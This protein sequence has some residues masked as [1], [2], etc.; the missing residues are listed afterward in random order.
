MPQRHQRRQASQSCIESEAVAITAPKEN[1][2]SDLTHSETTSVV[3]WLL[4]QPELNLTVSSNATI[5]DNKIALIELLTP[6]KTDAVTYLQGGAAPKRYAHVVLDVR[7]TLEPYYQDMTVGPLPINNM[8]TWKPYDYILTRKTDGK[9]PNLA[10]DTLVVLNE[11]IPPIGASVADITLD[12]WNGTATGLD[13]DTLSIWS[14]AE[15]WQ[16]DGRTYRWDR[17][18]NIQTDEFDVQSLLPL[19]LYFKSDVTGRDPSK[20][21]LEGWFYNDVFYETTE[22]FRTAYWAGLPKAPLNYEG[23]WTR[24]DQQGPVM[25]YDKMAP[26]VSVAPSGSRFAVDQQRKY[27]EWMDFSFYIGFRRDTGVALYDIRYKGELILYELGLQEAM[28]HYAGSDPVQSSTAYL[29]SEFGF[30]VYAFELV[31]GYDCPE[32]STYLNTSFYKSESTH[33]HLKSICLFEFTADYPVQRHSSSDY[34]SATKNTYFSLRSV[35]TIGNYDYMFTYSFFLD[36]SIS[37]EVRASGYVLTTSVGAPEFG[38]AIH[39]GLSGSIHDH[40][41]NFK[42]DFD[43]LGTSNTMQLIQNVPVT[44]VFPW[45][46]G[47][48]RNTMQLQRSFVESEN[49]SRFNW[50]GATQVLVV[51]TDKPNQWG[52][53]RGYRVAPNSGTARLTVLNSSTIANAAHWSEYDV[54]VT[55]RKDT[56]PLSAHPYNSQAVHDPPINFERFFDDKESLMQQ[57]LVLWLNLGMHHVPH[58]GDLPNTVFTT[59][60]SGITFMPSNYFDIDQTRRTVNMVRIDYSNDNATAVKTFGQSEATCNL[61]AKAANLWDYRG[62]VVVK[63]FPF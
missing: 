50:D 40:V 44:R 55:R 26:P 38:F 16:E 34:V 60:H 41:L 3:G 14:T 32:Y 47:K 33:T 28:A 37:I 51:N 7:A 17:F 4:A 24:T 54:Q 61:E 1:I 53:Y 36:G 56:E 27:V 9:V 13:N 39:K 11:W 46:N 15:P 52:E 21:K 30:G 2:W 18:W 57:D 59:A 63:K 23:D 22:E 8:T 35:S 12:L 43:I 6:N 49:E 10:A 19:G 29:D 5:W 62:D 31:T 48:P 58:T 20:W 42:A 25:P 45:S